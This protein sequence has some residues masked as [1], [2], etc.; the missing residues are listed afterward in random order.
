MLQYGSISKHYSKL[1]KPDTKGQMSDS[2]CVRRLCRWEVEWWWQGLGGETNRNLLFN[3]CRDPVW[4][5]D[6]VLKNVLD[7]SVCECP[8]CQWTISLKLWKWLTL[9]DVLLNTFFPSL[10]II[11]R[12]DLPV[13]VGF[14]LLIETFPLPHQS[15]L[16]SL[17]LFC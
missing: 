17:S 15:W 9:C 5:D 1:S 13:K 3:G 12:I 16:L 4:D 8:Q 6:K 11:S 14:R 10:F 2:I 7:L